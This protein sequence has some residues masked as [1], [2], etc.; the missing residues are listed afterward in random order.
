M[1]RE[2]LSW[3]AGFLFICFGCLVGLFVLVWYFGGTTVFL[4]AVLEFELRA[5]CLLSRQST[6]QVIQAASPF[7]ISYFS[8]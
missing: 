2:G 7:C 8:E 4:V 6:T 3:K 5:L 1:K